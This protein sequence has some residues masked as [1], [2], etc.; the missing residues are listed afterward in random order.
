MKGYKEPGF[1]DRVAIARNAKNKALEQMANRPRIDPEEQ[2]R[3]IAAQA[4]REEA[5]RIKRAAAQEA[6][7]AALAAK[8]AARLAKLEEDR[9]AAE[10]AIASQPRVLSEAELKAARDLRYAARKARKSGKS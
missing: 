7:Q 5:Q 10:M 6:K 4:A 3:R 2:A 8:E 1:Q 9:L